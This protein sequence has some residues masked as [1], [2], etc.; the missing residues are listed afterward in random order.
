[1]PAAES[2]ALHPAMPLRRYVEPYVYV[3][4]EVSPHIVKPLSPRPEAGIALN[5]NCR[6]SLSL[7]YGCGRVMAHP[8]AAVFGPLS[9]RF[10]DIRC[11]GHYR[12]FIILFRGTGYYRLFGIPPVE[13][14]D[15]VSDACDVIGPS[16]RLLHEQLCAA[17]NPARMAEIAD[18]Y[19]LSRLTGDELHPVHGMVEHIVSSCGRANVCQLSE[20]SGLS[21]RQ[22]ERKFL[23]Q[24]G[25][26][27]KRYARLARFRNAAR[28]KSLDRSLSWTD[29]SQAAGFYDH[30]HLVKDFRE[31]VGATPS[32]YLRS[33]SIAPATELWCTPEDE[34]NRKRSFAGGSPAYAIQRNSWR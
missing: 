16:V 34:P 2:A 24:I 26:T 8:A 22:I 18:R 4:T 30:N 10:A 21:A 7:E 28:L 20:S 3:D 25:I 1:V 33:I 29:V 14:A 17:N 23:E 12:A 11:T 5:L 27:A 9:H 6:D 31:L 13:L 19:L 15:R 32:D